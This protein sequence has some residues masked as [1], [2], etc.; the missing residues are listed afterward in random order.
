MTKQRVAVGMSGGVDSSVAALLLLKQGY[1]VLGV[2]MDF[3]HDDEG[4]AIYENLSDAADARAVCEVLGIEHL[5]INYT[6]QFRESVERDFIEEYRA[7]RTPNP[8]IVCNPAVKWKAILDAADER[9][10]E[11]VATGHYAKIVTTAAGRLSVIPS[12]SVGKDQSYVLYRL[13]QEQLRRTL[14]PIGD[15]DKNEV[16]RI[17]VDAG[18][19]VADKP[20]SQDICFVDEASYADY[21]AKKLPK[22]AF[23][24]GNFVDTSGNIL[25]CHKGYMRYTVGQRKGLGIA[26]GR[27][28]F[29]KRIDPKKNTVTLCDDEELYVRDV[30]AD[31]PYYMG[32]EVFGEDV[33]YTGRIRYSHRGEECRVRYLSDDRL[34]I[35]FETPVRAPA[36]GQSVVLYRDGYIAGGATITADDL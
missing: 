5:A 8:C 26:L 9:G 34:V 18:L 7:G 3:W 13:S 25:G 35:S 15:M 29:V 36:P 22:E 30:C 4:D 11:Y 12:Q 20:D 28:M 32:D 19:P 23:C 1:E 31:S 2:T 27:P 10:I 16:R 24:G 33:V 6:P 17:A 14:F 21:L